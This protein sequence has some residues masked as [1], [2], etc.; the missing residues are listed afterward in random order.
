MT[1]VRDL[2]DVMYT[3][4]AV[5]QYTDDPVPEELIGKILD[6]AVHAPSGSNSQRWRFIVITDPKLRATMGDEYAEASA[7]RARTMGREPSTP[8]TWMGQ[9]PVL[10]LC[11]L[12]NEPGAEPAK[13]TAGA[14]IYPA[15]QNM[16]LAARSF[17]IGTCLTTIHQHREPE[18]KA[19]LGIPENV[20]TYALIPMGYPATKFGPLS[21]KAPSEVSFRDRWGQP[22][23]I[24]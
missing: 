18:I 21:R 7:V 5:R 19:L 11:C 4:R 3:N 23:G 17:G 8:P 12:G 6:A 1:E 22:L 9:A 16:M 15:V 24:E 10:I 2:F 13:R 14:S 20:D